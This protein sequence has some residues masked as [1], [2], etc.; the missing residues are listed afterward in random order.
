MAYLLT[1]VRYGHTATLAASL[2]SSQSAALAARA[3]MLRALS[4]QSGALAMRMADRGKDGLAA[5]A[6]AKL[7]L[8]G[9]RLALKAAAELFEA[10]RSYSADSEDDDDLTRERERQR[11]TERSS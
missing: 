9:S 6:G 11:H 1:H 2:T 7:L 4:S 5:D 10:W 8:C 3:G